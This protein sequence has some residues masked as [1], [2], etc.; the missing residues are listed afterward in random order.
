ML[1]SNL[2]AFA[3]NVLSS[4]SVDT[5]GWVRVAEGPVAASMDTVGW[6]RAADM[7]GPKLQNKTQ[8]K[9]DKQQYILNKPKKCYTNKCLLTRCGFE[10]GS[11]RLLTR[12]GFEGGNQPFYGLGQVF[13]KHML[14]KFRCA[15]THEQTTKGTTGIRTQA[16]LFTRQAL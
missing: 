16:L 11:Q 14:R 5:E 15:K 10:G 6:Q 7:P 3:S 12:C 4:I 1:P 2:V 9:T 8:E 13:Q